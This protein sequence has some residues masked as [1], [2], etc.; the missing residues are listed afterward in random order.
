MAVCPASSQPLVRALLHSVHDEPDAI[1]VHAQFDQAL[2]ALA[3]RGPSSSGAG[4]SAGAPMRAVPALSASPQNSCPASHDPPRHGGYPCPDRQHRRCQ[5][6]RHR[7]RSDAHGDRSVIWGSGDARAAHHR[8]HQG[9]RKPTFPWLVA[10]SAAVAGLAQS[11]SAGWLPHYQLVR[12]ILP[13][14]CANSAPRPGETANMPRP[15]RDRCAVA[16]TAPAR[17]TACCAP[18]SMAR[19]LHATSRSHRERSSEARRIT[20]RNGERHGRRPRGRH[21]P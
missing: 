5:H 11:L 19:D 13:R 6:R 4:G 20:R 3:D 8:P 15:R 9:H 17:G 1:S 21:F 14:C 18:S 7:D 2:D 16:T 12:G 10:F